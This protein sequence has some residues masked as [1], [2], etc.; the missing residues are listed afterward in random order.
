MQFTLIFTHLATQRKS[1]HFII[2]HYLKIYEYAKDALDTF[3]RLDKKFYEHDNIVPR[4]TVE[5][6]K[7]AEDRLKEQINDGLKIQRFAQ[8]E[9]RQISIIFLG[10]DFFTTSDC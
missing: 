7:H 6:N 1:S 3:Q 10:S 5:E 4:P 8:F 2:P 9:W